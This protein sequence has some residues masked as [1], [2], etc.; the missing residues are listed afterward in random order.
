MSWV[1]AALL[2]L[3]VSAP[4]ADFQKSALPE[5]KLAVQTWT[6][7]RL[8]LLET[9]D[10][11]KDLGVQYLEVY[12]GQKLGKDLPGAFGPGMS[13]EA[14]KAVQAK[15]KE[16]GIGI[17][18][19]GVAGIPAKEADA[20]KM[21]EWAKSWGIEVINTEV[22]KGQFAVLDKLVTETGVKIGLHNHPKPSRLWNPDVIVEEAKDYKNIGACADTGHWPRSGLVALDCLKKLEG[23]ISSLH[24]KDVK[25]VGDRW[26]D[27]PWGT[28]ACEAKAMLAELK[29]QGF[30]GVI[31][32]EYEHVDAKLKDN[33]KACA[34][35]WFKTVKELAAA[36]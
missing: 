29:R 32:I 26:I 36:K 27:Q 25:K 24:F 4:A 33:V 11:V 14:T 30:K 21:L 17:V 35:W 9:I 31:S 16:A 18:A 1:G 28:G 8:T 22:G 5:W 2:A 13:E 34:E 23:R 19:L 20:R 6:F 7:N 3:T 10:V 15:L 12:P